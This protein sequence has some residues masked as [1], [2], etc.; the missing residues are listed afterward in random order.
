MKY[1]LDTDICIYIIRKKSQSAINHLRATNLLDVGI[2][3]IVLSELEYGVSKS[4]QPARNQQ[5]L[6]EFLLP[7]QVVS[8]DHLAAREYGPLRA[9]LE[10][11]GTVIGSLDMPIA[12]HAL[13]L[14]CELITN[15]E[16]E[17]R[18]VPGLRVQ[19]WAKG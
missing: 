18:R 3:S 2:S 7:I 13:A 6:T 5:A 4:S 15:N 14:S 8:Y 12:A 1:M 11:Q 16:G 17:F 10:K 19:N 9:H